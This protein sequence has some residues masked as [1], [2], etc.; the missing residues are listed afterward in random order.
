MRNRH[1]VHLLIVLLGLA[2]TPVVQATVS[3]VQD[4]TLVVPSG[5]VRQG[6][7]YS[8]SQTLN[9][10]GHQQG[11]LIGL[12]QSGVISGEVSGDVMFLL[13]NL[14]ITGTVHDAVRVFGE[15]L[16]I[17]GTVDGD[18]LFFGKQLNLATGSHVTGSVVAFSGSTFVDGTVDQ[19]LRGG[20]GQVQIT[21]TVHGNVK[22]ETDSFRIHPG[23]RIDGD[24]TYS[25]RKELKDL[26]PDAVG[27]E[28]VYEVDEE[29]DDEEEEDPFLTFGDVVWW[30]W[31]ALSS[32]L[33]GLV[34]LAIFRR[35][36]GPVTAPV[37]NDTM[38]GT[39]I[40][41]GVFLVVP[42]ASFLAM[43]LLIS[44]P[45]GFLLML[46]FLV[47]LYLAKMP[48]AIWVGEKI[49]GLAGQPSPSPFLA[50]PVGILVLYL[51]FEIPFM[52]GSLLWLVTTFLGLGA[53]ILAARGYLN[54]DAPAESTQA[55]A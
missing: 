35:A 54:G 38:L 16:T 24:L 18:V 15:T 30:G 29:E 47:A 46:I 5:Q 14:Q 23:G 48:V 6:D 41:F 25:A 4:A 52:L 27:G 11:D 32:M 45:L 43:V 28:I 22:V 19:D 3:G 42:M 44:L 36:V 10:A 53:M 39:L 33:V 21:G 7:I 26:E 51:L 1:A 50:L 8:M 31:G 12:A 55:T 2:V 34:A 37:G 13:N 9:I 17:S 49:L 20:A 40:G